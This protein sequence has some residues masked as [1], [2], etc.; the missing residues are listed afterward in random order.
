LEELKGGMPLSAVCPS[1][2]FCPSPE[3]VQPSRKRT[4]WKRTARTSLMLR[5]LSQN[6]WHKN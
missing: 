2:I 6:P 1:R 3:Q 4:S 5:L